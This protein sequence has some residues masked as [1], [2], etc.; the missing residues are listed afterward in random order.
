MRGKR[1]ALVLTAFT[2]LAWLACDDGEPSAAVVETPDAATESDAQTPASADASV[3]DAAAPL[4]CGA[5]LGADGLPKHLSCAGLYADVG[6]KV[7]APGNVAFT[8]GVELWS[9][10]AEKRRWVS[11]PPA[12]TIDATSFDEW[13]FPIGTRFFKEFA[14]AGKRIETRLY[15]KTAS[16]WK[17]V[18]Y[19]W[20]EAETEGERLDSAITVPLAG[21]TPYEIPKPADC[22]FCHAG[23]VEPV[24][25][26][27]AVG[28]G[29]AG[30]K[31]VTLA[32]LAAEGKLSPPPPATALV[33]PDDGTTKAAPAIGWLHANCGHCHSPKDGAGAVG[34]SLKMLVHASELVADGGAASASDLAVHKTGVCKVSERFD[35]NSGGNLLYIA[36]GSPGA[37]LVSQLLGSRAAPGQESIVNQ[38]PPILTHVVD[39][40]GRANVDAWVAALPPCP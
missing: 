7:V 17:H 13:R 21:R 24:L 23:R 8:P 39:E 31:G 29:L 5:D 33:I 40:N 16:G 3:P 20:N 4:D 9:D 37:S 22:D 1:L 12:T 25:G 6:A 34:S 19:R 30:A 26:F 2:P 36:G 38:M 27:D 11:L 10:G 32:T 35:P 28:L 14:I 18:T 15:T